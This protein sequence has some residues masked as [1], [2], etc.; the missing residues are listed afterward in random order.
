MCY[1]FLVVFDVTEL[2]AFDCV[3]IAIERVYSANRL[4]NSIESSDFL[5]S[6]FSMCIENRALEL[7]L[8]QL[9][10]SSIHSTER[11]R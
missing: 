6:T 10:A 2:S 5:R 9:V 7:T 4:N 8:K 1:K 11:F 3:K